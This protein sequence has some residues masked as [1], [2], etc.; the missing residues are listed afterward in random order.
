MTFSDQNTE[1]RQDFDQPG[2]DMAPYLEI[3]VHEK[4]QLN[5]MILSCDNRLW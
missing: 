2:M 1:S 4:F 5:R 3:I